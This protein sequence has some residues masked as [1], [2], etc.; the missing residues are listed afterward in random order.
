MAR[1]RGCVEPPRPVGCDPVPVR[2]TAA[3]PPQSG[4]QSLRVR[5]SDSRRPPGSA[6]QDTSRRRRLSAM[7]V[8]GVGWPLRLVAVIQTM[9]HRVPALSRG[10]QTTPARAPGTKIRDHDVVNHLL[11][12][13]LRGDFA[14]P[15][16]NDGLDLPLGHDHKDQDAVVQLALADPQMVEVFSCELRG[17]FSVVQQHDADLRRGLAIDL[18]DQLSELGLLRSTD[19]VGDLLP[20]AANPHVSLPA[21]RRSTAPGPSPPNSPKSPPPR[22]PAPPAAAAQKQAWATEKLAAA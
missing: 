6:A 2:Y 12:K 15:F 5:P 9:R 3:A 7:S 10:S 19:Q 21:S 1:E 16:A 11:A 4:F 8:P 14:E 13:R 18:L 17:F 20:P 22:S